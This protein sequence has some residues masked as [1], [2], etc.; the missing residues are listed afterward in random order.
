MRTIYLLRDK[1]LSWGVNVDVARGIVPG[2]NTYRIY[3][4]APSLY[5]QP[6]WTNYSLPPPDRNP[7]R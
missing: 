4:T 1:W 2:D 6:R 7:T 5:S 3:L